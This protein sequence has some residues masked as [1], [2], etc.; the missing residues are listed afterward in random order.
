MNAT[1]L[2]QELFQVIKN[3][4]PGHLSATEE[5]AK[6]LD[7]SVD[8]V[9][10]RMRGEKTISLE[11][12]HTLCS[13]YKISLDQ[14]MGIQTGAFTFQGNF[15]NE[16]TFRYEAFLQ[17]LLNNISYFNSFKERQCFN[18]GKD[19]PIFFHFI[20]REIA[21]FKYF[22]WMKTIFNFPGFANVRF[23]FN[24]YNDD[25]WGMGQ[26]I[27]AGYN[28]LPSVE[29][30]NVENINIAIRQI[31]FYRDG[32]MF[33]SDNDVLTL[34]ENWEKVINHIEKQA[35]RGY[36]FTYGDPEMKP[37]GEYK[38]YFNEVILGDNS[39][40]IVLNGVKVAILAHT[41]INYMMTRDMN[42]SENVYDYI[43]SLMRRSTLISQVS[44]K[45]RAKFFRI[46]RE[47]IAR[48]KDA[49]KV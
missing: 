13:H 33:E 30:W 45:E 22:F 11:E 20:F 15:L 48:R 41:N 47:R 44:E 21:A 1:E 39:L 27:I 19:V 40:V 29:L 43:Q 42:F 23:N 2:Q 38:V 4:I 37:I 32:Q 25:L 17:S 49:L 7:V 8:S 9:Y 12:L 10:R 18:L 6:V 5:I 26:K 31:E 34:Y 35:E 24:F 46:L 28:Q 14:L 16:K 3:N 36:K